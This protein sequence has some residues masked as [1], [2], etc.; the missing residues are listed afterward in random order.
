MISA[1][2]AATVLFMQAAPTATPNAASGAAP[3]AAPAG[4]SAVSPLTVTGKKPHAVDLDP[5]QTICHSESVVG[6]LFP[7]KICATRRE[8][9]ERRQQGQDQTDTFQRSPM[10]GVQFK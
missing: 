6:S 8:L 4:S 7:K 1:I 2:F 5:N 3:S 9:A 10:N